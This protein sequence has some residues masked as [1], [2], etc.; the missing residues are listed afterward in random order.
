VT[1]AQ[2][3]CACPGCHRHLPFG[4][5]ACRPHWRQLPPPLQRRIIAA[6]QRIRNGDPGG[7]DAHRAAVD[8]AKQVWGATP[9][10]FP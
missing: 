7:I 1:G 2:H 4:Q 5:L 9:V 6:W 10:L 3:S 8:E